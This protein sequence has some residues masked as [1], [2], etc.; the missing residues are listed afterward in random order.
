MWK[1]RRLTRTA[2]V[3]SALQSLKEAGKSREMNAL[4]DVGKMVIANRSRTQEAKGEIDA[5]FK[6]DSGGKAEAES[7][8]EVANKQNALSKK[9]SAKAIKLP[10]S[11]NE[12]ETETEVQADCGADAK[13]TER[14]ANAQDAQS[15]DNS[16]KAKSLPITDNEAKSNNGLANWGGDAEAVSTNEVVMAESVESR[17]ESTKT[18]SVLIAVNDACNEGKMS[19]SKWAQYIDSKRWKQRVKKQKGFR[20][21]TG[22]QSQH[23][24]ESGKHCGR[25][26]STKTFRRKS[27]R[28]QKSRMIKRDKLKVS[29]PLFNQ[30]CG[31]KYHMS[32]KKVQEAYKSMR[33][34][35]RFHASNR[36][37][38]RNRHRIIDGLRNVNR[39]KAYWEKDFLKT[40]EKE[41]DVPEPPE[42]NEDPHW[43]QTGPEYSSD[44][45][46][47]GPHNRVE[48]TIS[49]TN[50][51]FVE[52][53]LGMSPQFSSDEVVDGPNSVTRDSSTCDVQQNNEWKESI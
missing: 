29:V 36:I 41:Y 8:R 50:S 22:R 44:I 25:M 51:K 7:T 27:V 47:D 9:E 13:S 38:W 42:I 14:I 21:K 46:G 2:Y 18:Q 1:Q 3:L 26:C 24:V 43:Q 17:K 20:R 30:Q 4:D 37:L 48:A 32:L 28:K 6:A 40:K 11:V 52:V 10:I 39:I 45:A 16:A 35:R 19:P 33:R 31:P 5:V 12:A 34:G 49:T 23:T 53:I 15:I